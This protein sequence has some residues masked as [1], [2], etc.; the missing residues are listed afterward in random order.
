MNPGTIERWRYRLIPDHLVG[1]LLAKPWTETAIPVAVLLLVMAIMSAAVPSLFTEAGWA[2]TGRQVGEIGFVVLGLALVMMV[3]GVDLSIGSTFALC[4]FC[5]LYLMHVLKWPVYLAIP[6]TLALGAMLGAVNGLLVGYLRLRAFLTTLITLIIY[7]AVYD[8]LIQEHSTAIAGAMPDSVFWEALGYGQ[9]LGVPFVVWLYVLVAASAH[10]FITRLRPGWHVMAIG[11]SRRAAHNA[12]I[13]VRSTIAMTYVACGTLAACGAIFFASRLA[14]VGGDIGVGLEVTALT[15]AVL[16]G[17]SLGGGKGSATKAVVGT[18]I[19]LLIVNGLTVMGV[20]GGYNRMTLAAILLLAVIVDIRWVK[21][22]LDIVGK[23]YVSPGY[24]SLGPIPATDPNCGTPWAQNDRL[25]EVKLIGLGEIEGPEDV[26]LDEN[27]NL[28]CGSRHGDIVRFKAPDYQHMEVFAHIGGM[29]AGMAFDPQGCLNVC[30]AGM[31]LYKVDPNGQVKKVTDETNRSWITIN[32]DSRLRIADDLDIAPDGRIYFSEATTRY[33]AHD[34]FIDAI[35]ARGNGRLICHDPK[36][37]LTR[38]L[39]RN[40][41]FPNG[42]CMEVGGE[43]FLFAETWGCSVK[44]YW[45]SGPKA[46]TTEDV[47]TNLPGFPDNINNASD[48]NYWMALC[49]MRNPSLD[50]AWRM[51]GF[52]RRMT[53]RVAGDEWLFPNI[54]TGCIV[55]FDASGNVI[56]TLWDLGGVNHPMI[57]SMR[58]HKGRLFIGGLS[59]NRIGVIDLPNADPSFMQVGLH[60]RKA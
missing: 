57:T 40:L 24:H 54:N 34:W 50:L 9:W 49:G 23:V 6:S 39:L 19:V 33:E 27:D 60:W 29:P 47:M 28:Y 42:I 1:E 52:R 36:T 32:D 51:P 15:A 3:G 48:G 55:K 16:G 25:R 4:N 11:G 38:T 58:E 14:T 10:V 31:G 17:I 41:R 21:N 43:S 13:A 2:D 44:R 12:G 56:E 45:I 8:L 20:S 7:R 30:I 5:A 35:E 22:R 37:G 46:H 18:L 59:N 26:I 53:A